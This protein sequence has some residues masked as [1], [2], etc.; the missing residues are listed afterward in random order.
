MRNS[1]GDRT[2]A[3]GEHTLYRHVSVRSCPTFHWK[4]AKS[5]PMDELV[6]PRRREFIRMAKKQSISMILP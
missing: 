4:R 3:S 5:S 1:I 2:L 6:S